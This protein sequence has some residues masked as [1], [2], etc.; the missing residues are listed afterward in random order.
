[1]TPL[2]DGLMWG[3]EGGAGGSMSGQR[4]VHAPRALGSRLDAH[5]G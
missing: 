2:L 4:G 1:M 3:L 5:E